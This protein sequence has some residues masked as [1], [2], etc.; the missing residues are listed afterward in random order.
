MEGEIR[1]RDEVMR[2]LKTGYPDTNR[3]SEI[4]HNYVRPPVRWPERHK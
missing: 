1:N 4:Y 3:L 2:R